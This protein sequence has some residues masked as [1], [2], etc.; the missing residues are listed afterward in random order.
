V[1]AQ[2]GAARA[3]LAVLEAVSQARRARYAPLEEKQSAVAALGALPVQLLRPVRAAGY[4]DLGDLIQARA[5]MVEALISAPE[6]AQLWS[7]ALDLCG[8]DE[9][10]DLLAELARRGHPPPARLQSALDLSQA[11]SAELLA[12]QARHTGDPDLLLFIARIAASR[13]DRSQARAALELAERAAPR[14][15][16]PQVRRLELMAQSGQLAEAEAELEE[17]L[18]AWPHP[19]LVLLW[20]DLAAQRGDLGEARRRLERLPPGV[21]GERERSDLPGVD[22]G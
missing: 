12:A 7:A 3:E 4:A 2:V 8:P 15:P 20:A 21:D 9:L 11:G 18:K 5:I 10:T 14:D 6:E 17:A 16:R 13:G 19:R 22:L 1:E